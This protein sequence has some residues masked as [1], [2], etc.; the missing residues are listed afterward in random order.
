MASSP[1]LLILGAGPNIGKSVAQKFAANGYKVALASR[2]VP[3]TNDWK[4]S[5]HVQSDLSKPEA[6]KDI[7]QQVREKVGVPSFVL[8][9]SKSVPSKVF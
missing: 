3:T 5:L 1:V 2:R 9:N 7:F 6:V 4:E 8:F